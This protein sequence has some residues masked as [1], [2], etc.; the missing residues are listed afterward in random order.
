MINPIPENLRH[1]LPPVPPSAE[2]LDRI[3]RGYLGFL[4]EMNEIEGVPIEQVRQACYD[5]DSLLQI[6][7]TDAAKAGAKS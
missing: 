6:L 2:K 1:L 7:L 5:S 4:R 3:R